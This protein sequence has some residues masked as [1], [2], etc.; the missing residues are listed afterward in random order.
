VNRPPLTRLQRVCTSITRYTMVCTFT[1]ALFVFL[2]Q[3][4]Q[5]NA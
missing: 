4:A 2:F 1:F 5:L 3:A